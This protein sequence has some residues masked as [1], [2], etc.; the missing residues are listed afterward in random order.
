MAAQWLNNW[1]ADAA[2][3]PNSGDKFILEMLAARSTY[4]PERGG[5]PAGPLPGPL[6]EVN[7]AELARR[8]LAARKAMAG[9]VCGQAAGDNAPLVKYIEAQNIGVLRAHL[10]RST[11]VSGK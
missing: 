4:L 6:R 7:P 3:K 9:R 10:N 2:N 5:A 11:Y 1:M 8:L